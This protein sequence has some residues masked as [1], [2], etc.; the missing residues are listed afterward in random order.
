MNKLINQTVYLVFISAISLFICAHDP[1]FESMLQSF[2]NVT[3]WHDEYSENEIQA[4][5]HA[6]AKY[7]KL[8]EI[9]N[10]FD[11]GLCQIINA[12]NKAGNKKSLKV[13][14][15][16]KTLTLIKSNVPHTM[17]LENNFNATF[18]PASELK[19]DLIDLTVLKERIDT[20]HL[21]ANPE[22][23]FFLNPYKKN[24]S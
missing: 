24:Y 12:V 19:K 8:L 22:V 2:K 23:S 15:Q 1:E 21:E 14:V 5:Q 6:T 20:C 10:N 9:I 4:I 13:N 11:Q 3:Q 16:N 17:L 18:K 7:K